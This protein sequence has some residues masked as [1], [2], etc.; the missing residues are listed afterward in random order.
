M[1]TLL[2][3][4]NYMQF[5]F[6]L[7]RGGAKVSTRAEHVRE[8]IEQVLFTVP[9]ERWYRPGF[10]GAVRQLVFEPS[11]TVLVE[12]T[13]KRISAALTESLAGEITPNSL[14]VDVVADGAALTITIGYKV[15]TI[16]HSERVEFAIGAS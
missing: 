9:G 15:A 1:S 8:Q 7:G 10:G 3:Q 2:N 13:K 12:L 14:E 16:N 5:P 11:N 6:S 4:A